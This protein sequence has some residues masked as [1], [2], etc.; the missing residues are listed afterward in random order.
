[1]R[2]DRIKNSLQ[3]DKHSL[4]EAGNP[5]T[6]LL[7]GGD[8]P[9]KIQIY[10][11]KDS[12]KLTSHRLSQP[13]RYTGGYQNQKGGSQAKNN[14]CPLATNTEHD[15]AHNTKTT[16]NIGI[17]KYR[18]IKPLDILSI[19]AYFRSRSNEFKAGTLK[20]SFH[21]WKELTSN[22]EILQTVL[23]LKLEFLSDPPVKDNSYIPR[24]SKED[25]SAIDLEVQKLLVKGVITKC[26]HETGEYIYKTKTRWFMQTHTK[27]EK[28]K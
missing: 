28:P 14:F 9:K 11:A 20:H 1:M 23:A 19:R 5:P 16:D 7:L 8:L 10:E 17:N 13:P 2:R 26:E 25:Q 15:I 21:K 24:F 3:K 12:S 27:S 22:K 18:S 4:C 6:T